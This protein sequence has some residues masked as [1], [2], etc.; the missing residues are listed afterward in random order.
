M[1]TSEMIEKFSLERIQKSGAV[2]DIKKLDWLN[3]QYLKEKSE[4]ELW[5]K[6]KE[7]YG[8]KISASDETALKLLKMGKARIAKLEDFFSL[9]ES[10]A[11]PDYDGNLLSWK[12]TP[13]ETTKEAL[14]LAQEIV[15]T[16]LIHEFNQKNLE[17]QLMPTADSQ[18]RGE[19]LWPLRTALSGKDKS[20]GPFELMEVL[21]KEESLR[22]IDIAIKKLES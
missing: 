12:N 16:I 11:L 17:T 7:L 1:A 13:K 2:F 10:L 21:G 4:S 19:F 9:Q 18:G 15:R 6:I 8:K 22:R 5:Q 3:S 14:R 20:P